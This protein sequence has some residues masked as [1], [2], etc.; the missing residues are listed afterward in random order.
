MSWVIMKS[1]PV[2]FPI[3][4]S[5]GLKGWH[6]KAYRILSL[7]KFIKPKLRPSPLAARLGQSP[8]YKEV[9]GVI[10][11]YSHPKPLPGSLGTFCSCSGK[12]NQ[13]SNPCH[14][15]DIA[16]S[17]QPKADMASLGLCVHKSRQERGGGGGG[18]AG[19]GKQSPASG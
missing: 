14:C 10:R 5:S 3:S 6:I 16:E 15:R 2:V 8:H 13:S 7:L 4:L 12:D 17:L 11:A 1:Q 18:G 19:Q 9:L